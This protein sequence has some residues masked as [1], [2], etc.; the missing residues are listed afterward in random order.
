MGN[1]T[2]STWGEEQLANYP[3]M[4][5]ERRMAKDLGSEELF[6]NPR[7]IKVDAQGRVFVVDCSRG[8]IQIYRKER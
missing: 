7:G 5:E 1:A 6:S 8:R 2:V 3:E 4:L